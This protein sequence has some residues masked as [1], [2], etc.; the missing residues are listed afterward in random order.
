MW[1][2][3][4]VLLCGLRAAWKGD[5][6]GLGPIGMSALLDLQVCG[7]ALLTVVLLCGLQ[8]AVPAATLAILDCHQAYSYVSSHTASI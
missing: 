2:L 5:G 8:A 3:T 7:A 4:V 1:L 6:V